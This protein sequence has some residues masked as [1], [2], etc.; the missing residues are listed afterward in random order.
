[1]K[2]TG[3]KSYHGLTTWSVQL[4]ATQTDEKI[5]MK[6][7]GNGKKIGRTGAIPVYDDHDDTWKIFRNVHV[8]WPGLENAAD[9]EKV[10]QLR[11]QVNSLLDRFP[12]TVP[13]LEKRGVRVKSLLSKPIKTPGLGG[14]SIAITAGV[15]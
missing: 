4:N 6:I 3:R 15:L 7:T 13:Q 11:R 14:G 12:D 1:M 10:D 5:W 8:I 2:K 9:P